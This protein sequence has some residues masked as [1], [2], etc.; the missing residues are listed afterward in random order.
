MNHHLT[1]I[2]SGLPQW[3]IHLVLLLLG[4]EFVVAVIRS[5]I[6]HIHYEEGMVLREEKKEAGPAHVYH[7]IKFN[8]QLDLLL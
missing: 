3:T 5:G 8:A 1:H 6:Y 2:P 4:V 7:E